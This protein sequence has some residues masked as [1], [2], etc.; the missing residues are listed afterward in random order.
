M[1]KAISLFLLCMLFLTGCTGKENTEP[2][3]EQQL[4]ETGVKMEVSNC[5]IVSDEPVYY[6][7][8]REDIGHWV[9][10][11]AIQA[12]GTPVVT[13]YGVRAEQVELRFAENIDW[14]YLYYDKMLPQPDLDY[15]MTELEDGVRYRLDTIYNYEF[16]VTT[17]TG[18]D[19]MLV[20][21]Q[22]DG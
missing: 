9:Q 18:T 16:I 2:V 14:L 17:D 10:M 3:W 8:D 19:N 1:K 12:Q 20:I 7:T 6:T 5:E 13:L 11:P 4:P 15:I 21:S 22:L